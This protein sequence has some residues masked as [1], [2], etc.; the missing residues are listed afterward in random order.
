[1]SELFSNEYLKIIENENNIFRIEFNYLNIALINSLIKTKLLLGAVCNE[2]YD[3]VQFK[4]LSVKP[5][6]EYQKEQKEMRGTSKI[7]IKNALQLLLD[8]SVQLNY[9]ITKESCSFLGYNLED[10]FVINDSKFIFLGTELIKELNKN[11]IIISNPFSENDFFVSPELLK[12]KDIPSY[13]HYKSVYFS[14]S[15]LL[16]Y[17]LSESSSSV[18][19]YNEYLKIDDERRYERLKESLNMLSIRETKLYWVLSRSLIE[20]CEKRNILFI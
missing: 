17:L 7:S 20:D 11:K 4:A 1:M 14:L 6:I 12:I 13:I 8:L 5:F 3:I 9:L 18:E 16:L 10:I 15:F 2:K 19:I